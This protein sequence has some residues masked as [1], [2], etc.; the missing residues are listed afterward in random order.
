MYAVRVDQQRAGD[1][2]ELRQPG[3]VGVGPGELG[4]LDPESPTSPLQPWSPAGEPFP[5]HPPLA[6]DPRSVSITLMSSRAQPSAA[7]L[8]AS[9]YWSL[10]DSVW[11]RTWAIEDSRR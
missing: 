5:R 8:S 7:A 11:S 3:D 2:G 10:V 4:D 1:P 6:G 9:A